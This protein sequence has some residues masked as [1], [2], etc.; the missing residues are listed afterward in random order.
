M[1]AWFHKEGTKLV[2]DDEDGLKGM[3]RMK[4]RESVLVSVVRP[5]V[6]SQLRRY[7]AICAEIGANQDPP[8]DKDSIDHELRIRAGHFDVILVD[9]IECRIPKR[10]AFEKLNQDGWEDYLQR[11]ELAISETFGHEYLEQRAA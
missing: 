6:A 8:R 1:S 3:L 9:G 2:P 11:V 4:E 5:R 10:I 7:F